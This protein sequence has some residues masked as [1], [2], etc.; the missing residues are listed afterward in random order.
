MF[1]CKEKTSR[2]LILT[3][4]ESA[5]CLS[6]E[7]NLTDLS[8]ECPG[9]DVER[10]GYQITFAIHFWYTLCPVSVVPDGGL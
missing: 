3:D 4:A 5:P 6:A 9:C 7:D 1:P 10:I 8:G 2:L